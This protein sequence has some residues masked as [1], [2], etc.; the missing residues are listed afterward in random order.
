MKTILSLL[1]VSL[2]VPHAAN[3]EGGR[4]Q[5]WLQTRKDRN[6]N[7]ELMAQ[8]ATDMTSETYQGREMLVHIPASLPPEGRRAMVVVLHGGMGNATQIHSVLNLVPTADKY[9]FVVAYLN[10]SRASKLGEKFHAWNAGDQCCGQ[11]FKN[12]IDDVGYIEGAVN[13]LAQ[14]YG[15]DKDR[16]YGMGHSNGAMMTSRLLCESDVFAAGIPISGPLELDLASCPAAKGKKILAIHGV[17]DVN[18]P[19]V[20]G[21]GTKGV[22]D[23]TFKSEAYAQK[24]FEASGAA[25][26]LD[27]VAGVDHNLARIG[28]AIQAKEGI[29]LPEKAAAFFA[30]KK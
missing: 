22:T 1:L 8:P 15:I 13:H 17:D 26:T 10:G 3:A 21:N 28:E 4:L 25:F 14:E 24:I 20:G 12:N 29:S 6:A 30:L 27:T 5:Q 19:I 2:L 7:K 11:P 18:V 23:V 9:G 16:V